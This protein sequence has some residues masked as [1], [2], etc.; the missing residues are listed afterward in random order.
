MAQLHDVR[1]MAEFEAPIP[2]LSNE[3][4]PAA[5]RGLATVLIVLFVVSTVAAVAV[6][7]PETVTGTF[8]IV[9]ARGADPVRAQRD[10]IVED[11]RVDEGRAVAKG[12]PMFV[13]RSS[14]I[15]DRAAELRGL[16][17]TVAGTASRLTNTTREHA[18]RRQ[19][20]EAEIKRLEG[21]V[22]SLG[23]VI[24]L[25]ERRQRTTREL[26]DS[27]RGG[28][29]TGA[30][31]QYEQRQLELEADRLAT[32]IEQ[33]KADMEDARVSIDR[34]RLDI[35][36]RDAAHRE[37]LRSIGQERDM[38]ESRAVAVREQLAVARVD[39]GGSVTVAATCAGTV[40][41]LN[42]AAPGA[43]VREGDVLGEIA[44]DGEPLVGDLSI[45]QTGVA[46]IRVG[47]S[48]KLR[49][50]AFPYQR[51]GV[52]A[53]TVRWVGPV[54]GGGG[55][56]GARDFRALV[57][58]GTPSIVVNGKP[59]PLQPGLRGKADVVVGRR[60]LID[61]V[62]DPIRQLRENFSGA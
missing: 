6:K 37:L 28:R 4:P 7:M 61:F 19:S 15:G 9:P 22:A 60:T 26:A 49:Y 42:V 41:R 21:R 43:L 23:R 14:Q 5:A 51:F 24:V 44:C 40:L 29:S 35:D 17:L 31:S 62:L 20:D 46:R 16:D 3:P 18:A 30:V 33:S 10:G 11:V 36:A 39:T 25:Q 55:A 58:V 50:D 8:L 59:Q 34:L 54:G 57:D 32:E 45:A 52:Q 12:A 53:G 1:Q 27:Y 56:D 13:I 47:Q 48:V 2:F 38:S